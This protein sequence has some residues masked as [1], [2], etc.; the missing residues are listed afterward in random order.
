MSGNKGTLEITS[1]I[2]L[3]FVMIFVLANVLSVTLGLI[4]FVGKFWLGFFRAL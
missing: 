1:N 2:F 4:W 3:A